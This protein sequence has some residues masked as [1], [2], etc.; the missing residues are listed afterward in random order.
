MEKDLIEYI[1]KSLVDDPSAVSVNE[2]EGERG[3]VLELRVAQG[4]IGKVIGK[5][6]RIAKALRTVLS[7]SASRDGRH[8]SLDILD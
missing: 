2:T 5:Y 8:Y 6:G 4:D 3:P 1:A 7:A